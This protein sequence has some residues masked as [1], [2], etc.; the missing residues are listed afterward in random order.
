MKKAL[1]CTLLAL[2]LCLSLG[3]GVLADETE[4]HFY[5]TVGIFDN[6]AYDEVETRLA[7]LSEGGV[8]L[9]A[10]LVESHSDYGD[11][12]YDAAARLYDGMEFGAGDGREG[13]FLLAE[14]ETS[15]GALYVHGERAEALFTDAAQDAILDRFDTT[16]TWYD[17]M[18][19]FAEDCE[20]L[21]SGADAGEATVP[22]TGPE[23]TAPPV[24][25]APAPTAAPAATETPAATAA[26]A[27]VATETPAAEPEDWYVY[28]IA[29][30][31]TDQ[32]LDA[33][34]AKLARISEKYDCGVYI[35]AVEDYA[36]YGAGSIE[37]VSEGIYYNEGF[38]FGPNRDGVFL[39]MSMSDRD[40]D[41]FR[42]GWGNEAISPRAKERVIDAFRD[43]FRSD[44]WYG[45]FNDFADTC[46]EMFRVA[47]A[48]EPYG[49]GM[50]TGAK[51][52]VAIIPALLIAFIAC[53]VMKAKMKSVRLA[54]D[55]DA[56][57]AP[58][59]LDLTDATDLYTHTTETRRKIQSSSR[60]GGGGGSSHSS[61]KF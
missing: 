42:N 2:L 59:S 32:Q 5:D 26:P 3:A 12:L 47:A 45:G 30:L 57:T 60:S 22:R 29:G 27:P 4:T 20:A 17:A 9:Y 15:A 14:T 6:D 21:L 24:V 52:A 1:L 53:A 10:A 38:G 34:E 50:S 41:F 13:V 23:E 33:L 49:T 16:E 31:L 19:F 40:Y 36:D 8:A 37:D 43:N 54:A 39:F 44:D 46:E 48:G 25:S 61:G 58:G 56:Y 55:A 18:I 35:A 51:L 11:D 7:E 28:D